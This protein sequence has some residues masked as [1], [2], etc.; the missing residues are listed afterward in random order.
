MDQRK[1]WQK[2]QRQRESL[3]ADDY[4]VMS[5]DDEEN[6]NNRGGSV[7]QVNRE[8]AARC[9]ARATHRLAT[10]EEIE[11]HIAADRRNA[12]ENAKKE[13][14]RK[15]PI[16]ITLAPGVIVSRVEDQPE[17]DGSA[18]AKAKLKK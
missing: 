4:Y 12:A 16:N 13:L 17:H 1:F 6:S 2:V 15:Q 3:T 18:D 5:L 11:R 8:V 9:I 14:D 10:P 7:T